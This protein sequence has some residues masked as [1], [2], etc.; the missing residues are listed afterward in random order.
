MVN[1]T[2]EEVLEMLDLGGLSNRLLSLALNNEEIGR[3]MCCMAGILA[4]SDHG[5]REV[6]EEEL[7]RKIPAWADLELMFLWTAYAWSLDNE[8]GDK[9]IARQ[10][11]IDAWEFGTGH[12][13]TDRYMDNLLSR[14]VPF[15]ENPSPDEFSSEAIERIRNV[16]LKRRERGE[17][18]KHRGSQ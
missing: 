4:R 2:E 8:G 13:L 15:F 14:S 5:Y 16:Y 11:A 1:L 6:L 12:V 3:R 17:K 7:N 18:T 10:K 9:K